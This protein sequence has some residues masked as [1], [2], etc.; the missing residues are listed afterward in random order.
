MEYK[1]LSYYQATNRVDKKSFSTLTDA[2]D[3]YMQLLGTTGL[4]SVAL[5]EINE[6]QERILQFNAR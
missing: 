1:V 4:I 3:Y 2:V 6:Q 5:M